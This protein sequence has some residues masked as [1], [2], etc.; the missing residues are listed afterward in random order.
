M[1]HRY[2]AIVLTFVG[3]TTVLTAQAPAPSVP[4]PADWPQ[5]RGPDRTGLSKE[6]GLLKQ[7]PASGPQRVWSTSNLG[8]GYGS[9]AVK[10]D[11]VFVQGS[12]P[13]SRV[14]S[15]IYSPQS[16]LY[17]LNRTDG[18]QLWSKTIG[19][20]GRDERGSGPRGTPTVDE[21]RVY[22][23]TENGDLA[24]LK[25]ADGTMVWQK[26]I[27]TEFRGRNIDWMISESPLID[28]NHVIV[29][30]GGP[31][32]SMVALDK[33]TGKTVWTSKELSDPAGYASPIVADV[34]G[35]RTIM[36]LTSQ[37]GVGVRASDGK[38]MWRYQQVANN[39][40]NIATPVFS[41]NRVFYSSG[42][43]TGGAL[44]G[45]TA[46]GGLVEAK[47]IYFTR[48]MQNHHGG[49]L[50]V[51]QHLY[52]YN[53]AIL[54]CLEFQ[55][56]KVMWR[57]RSVGKGTLT[58]ADGHF[59]VLGEENIVGLVE[60]SPS[61]YREKGRFRIEDQGF[62]SWAHPVVAGGRLYIRNQGT[63]TAYDVRAR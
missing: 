34:Q 43:D 62:P 2:L 60:A 29:S 51:G 24:C 49:V 16:I 53:D 50:V 46:K 26:N 19:V 32:A 33:M 36:T 61:G 9:I 31:Q 14:Q 57:D 28:G 15:L 23:L 27:L 18:K 17:V 39:T 56:G 35:V 45:L 54:A 55:T 4:P 20:G 47:E 1:T 21:D 40:A 41:D 44:L 6:T 38:L 7:W 48:A 63:L 22:V 3:L 25:V 37:A 8:A 30:P 52:G 12:P 13:V 58:Y 42:Y 59:Y 11:R 5:W 10:G